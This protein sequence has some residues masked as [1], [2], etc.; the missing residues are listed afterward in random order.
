MN[1]ESLMCQIVAIAQSQGIN[2]KALAKRVGVRE[3]TLS[4]M[5]KRGSAQLRFVEALAKSAGVSLGLLTQGGRPAP[6]HPPSSPPSFQEKYRVLAWA[7][8]KAS[9]TLLLRRALVTPEFQTLL[10]ASIEFG[11]GAVVSEWKVLK[12]SGDPEV[13]R[14]QPIT[15]RLLQNIARGYEQATA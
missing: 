8:P 1:A 4:R 2:Q 6:S 10:D 13:I 3:E 11:V 14:A 5:K 7:N 9:P 15:E 12:E